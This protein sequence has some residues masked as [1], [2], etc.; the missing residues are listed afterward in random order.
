ML[1]GA[2]NSPLRPMLQEIEE[3]GR[4]GFD[5]VEL[6]MDPPYAHHSVISEQRG[7][8]LEALERLGMG[9]VCHLP[10]FVS[11]AD[12]TE[13]LREASI[14]ET[15]L[16]LRAASDLKPIKAVLHPS[17]IQGL[18]AMVK[19]M[20]RQY[21]MESLERIL[22]EADFLSFPICVENLFPRSLSLVNP[23]DFDDLFR[24]FPAARLALDTGHA[25]I[26]QGGAERIGSFI[27]RHS[28]RI[29]HVHASDNSGRED[30]HLPIGVGSIDFL[31]I[32][33]KLREIGYDDTITLEVFA[34]DRDYLRISREK[35]SA[36]F[37]KEKM[38]P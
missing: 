20:A 16:S 4:L 9:L 8:L 18:G 19:D 24:K 17:F 35:L 3:I 13:S 34:R 15:I 10:T 37:A 6:T 12:L 38:R 25:Y 7:A 28:G 11:T 31:S 30:E 1:Y 32:V 29:G 14:Q 27:S 26:G 23:E 21:A 5:Y 33:K 36:M 2:M 22:K